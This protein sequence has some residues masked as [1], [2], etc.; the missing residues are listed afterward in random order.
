[1]ATKLVYLP[2]HS[3]TSTSL[4][5]RD[6]FAEMENLILSYTDQGTESSEESSSSSSSPSPSSSDDEGEYSRSTIQRNSAD[7]PEL[8]S[9]EASSDLH[10]QSNSDSSSADEIDAHET[11]GLDDDHDVPDD[12]GNHDSIAVEE[13]QTLVECAAQGHDVYTDKIPTDKRPRGYALDPTLLTA[14]MSTFLTDLRDFWT[15][16]HNLLR[17][18]PPITIA[19]FSKTSER[20]MC[21]YSLLR[22][23]FQRQHLYAQP[24][25]QAKKEKMLGI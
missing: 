11:S 5:A 16:E 18:A 7:I 4:H 24:S 21:K 2:T 10:D 20:I 25:F 1:M 14:E 9:D 6:I 17:R 3:H 22:R 13:P 15:R 23:K 12:N 8:Q 19:T